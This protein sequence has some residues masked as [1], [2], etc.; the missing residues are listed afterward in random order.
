M[1]SVLLFVLMSGKSDNFMPFN[2]N[3]LDDHPLEYSEHFRAV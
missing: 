1:R 3:V 2:L